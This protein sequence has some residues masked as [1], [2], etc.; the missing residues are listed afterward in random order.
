KDADLEMALR[1]CE[2]AKCQRPGTCNAMESL[3][4]HAKVAPQ[5]LPLLAKRFSDLE[6]ELRGDAAARTIVP[7]MKEATEE[8]WS[9]EYLAL[10][11]SVKVV[12]STED[13]TAHINRYG[14][15]HSDAIISGNKSAQKLFLQ[16][17]DSAAV[18]V[19]ASTRF[20]DGGEFGMGAEIGIS[21]DK[22]HARGPMG[23]EELTSYKYHINGNGQVRD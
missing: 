4:V 1:I 22:L 2:N 19:N 14:T 11:L 7:A 21:T 18:Y 15:H 20:T 10:K 3:L 12:A 9:T 5:F 6:V 13:A 23:L 16:R 8:D 17:V